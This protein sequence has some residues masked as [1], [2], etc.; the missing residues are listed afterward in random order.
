MVLNFVVPRR[1]RCAGCTCGHPRRVSL[2]LSG[3]VMVA[4][5][6]STL[7]RSTRADIDPLSGVDFVTIT[8][9]GNAPWMGDGTLDDR[10]IGRGSVGYEYRIGRFEVTTAQWVEFFN[11]AFDRPATDRIP[12]VTAPR[13]W[14]GI[15]VSPS[16]PG[17]R[18]WIAPGANGMLP[19]GNISWRTAAIYCNWLCNGKAT[20][21]DAFLT[22]A[23]DVSTFGY[24]FNTFTDQQVRTPGAPYFIPTWD[25][26]LKA[27]HFDPD[28]FG[29][30]QP[31]WWTG[32]DSTNTIPVGGPPGTGDANHRNFPGWQAVPL[33]AYPQ[34]QSPWGSSTLPVL[35]PN[36]PK[37]SSVFRPTPKSTASSMD[38]IG[39]LT[40]AGH[41]M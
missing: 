31:G 3:I 12:H 19:T 37:P 34:T 30:G 33:G 22:G 1:G 13:F 20:N 23:Y 29:D 38:R 25:E 28:R 21:R 2:G 8:H 10:A 11:A 16:T 39:V 35:P 26:W 9:A 36:G 24:V 41:S 5:A 32:P 15:E 17:G 4:L 14:G 40:P 27:V 7:P 6:S 18:R